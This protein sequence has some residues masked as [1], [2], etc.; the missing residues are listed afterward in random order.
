MDGRAT[1][2]LSVQEVSQ[3]DAA[4]G[5]AGA[6]QSLGSN[7][8]RLHVRSPHERQVR[9]VF[10]RHSHQLAVG[11]EQH[12][13][14]GQVLPKPWNLTPRQAQTARSTVEIPRMQED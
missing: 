4:L 7:W 3:E 8:L 11:V 14:G 5:L 2:G 1:K 10:L 13:K 12:G 6:P 9:H